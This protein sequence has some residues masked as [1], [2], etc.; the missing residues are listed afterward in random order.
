MS[1]RRKGA[2]APSPENITFVNRVGTNER[3]R[4]DFRK[5]VGRLYFMDGA[6]YE[7]FVDWVSC[8]FTVL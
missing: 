2:L 5:P 8:V 4:K 7:T 1:V 6:H 3:M